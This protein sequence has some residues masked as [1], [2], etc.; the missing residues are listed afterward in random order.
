MYAH[1]RQKRSALNGTLLS[2]IESLKARIELLPGLR[3]VVAGSTDQVI[4]R[5]QWFAISNQLQAVANKLLRQL[6][7]ITEGYLPAAEKEPGSDV[8]ADKLGDLELELSVAFGFYDTCMDILTQRLS[9]D[10]GPLLRG[11]DAIA[12]DGLK[13]DYLPGITRNPIVYCDRGF[14]ASILREGVAV[15]KTVNPVAFIAIPYARLAEKYNLISIYHEVGHQA[16]SKLNLVDT[17]RD[18]F[19]SVVKNEGGNLALQ[20]MFANWSKEI[21][22]DFWAFAHTGMGQ[23][24]SMKDILLVPKNMAFQVS[25][26]QQHPPSYLRFLF[27][28]EWCRFLWGRGEW[29]S[30]EE[31][32]DSLYPLSKE[33]EMTKA[34]I[35][36]AKK[37]LPATAASVITTRLKK[38]NR[39]PLISLFDI[40]TVAPAK[41]RFVSANICN[42]KSGSRPIGV[43]LAGFRLLR[44]QNSIPIN[45]IN[46]AMKKWLISLTPTKTN[47]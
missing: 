4:T 28:V 36:A 2:K 45:S 20:S 7:G 26:Y 35:R 10:L 42:D 12:A 43:Q 37:L 25:A 31:E 14:G 22:P 16:M 15:S 44:D 5:D 11:C 24:S 3:K 30:W 1:T 46:E 47:H 40:D 13:H 27:S 9:A 33:N 6:D 17:F 8:L 21:V 41:L 38:L 29:D 34:N 18:V 23:T 32:W 39:K 19:A